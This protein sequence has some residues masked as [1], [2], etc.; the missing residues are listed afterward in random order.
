MKLIF[1]Y[2][3]GKS[4]VP[5]FFNHAILISWH[6]I[7]WLSPGL[8]FHWHCLKKVPNINLYRD[9]FSNICV[10][11]D[12]MIF[13][14]KTISSQSSH[15]CAISTVDSI[16]QG[17]FVVNHFPRG[18]I[19]IFFLHPEFSSQRMHFFPSFSEKHCCIWFFLSLPLPCSP[20]YLPEY[21]NGS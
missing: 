10:F 1:Q 3:R 8:S 4:D 9:I 12:R 17:A 13:R 19:L 15:R 20:R 11:F 16:S 5:V 2:V 21:M 6:E 14:H 18:V 7:S